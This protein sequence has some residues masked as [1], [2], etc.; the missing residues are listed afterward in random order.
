MYYRSSITNKIVS[1]KFTKSLN[2]IYGLGTV[3]KLV[4]E[5]TLI[6]IDEPTIIDCIKDG[7]GSVA[8]VRYMEINP[9][10]DWAT[11]SKEVRK[12]RKDM[13]RNKNRKDSE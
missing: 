4:E 5:G 1:E 9:D 6:P 12:I 3:E 11:A 7:G 8:T 2:Y 13:Y 10:A